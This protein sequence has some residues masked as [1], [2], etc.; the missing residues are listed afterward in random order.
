METRRVRAVMTALVQPLCHAPG[1]PHALGV[2]PGR[3]DAAPA[4]E[5]ALRVLA[6]LSAAGETAEPPVASPT[7]L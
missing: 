1:S 7:M 3:A 6:E 2:G 5:R 4:P